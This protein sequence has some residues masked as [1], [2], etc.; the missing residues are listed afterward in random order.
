MKSRRISWKNSMKSHRRNF[1]CNPRFFKGIPRKISAGTH[2]EIL[3]G[4]FELIVSTK[5]RKFG[6]NV[7]MSFTRNYFSNTSI[8][9]LCRHRQFLENFTQTIHKIFPQKICQS[10]SFQ[11]SYEIKL[12]VHILL[13]DYDK[14]LTDIDNHALFCYFR[15]LCI[16]RHDMRCFG[17]PVELKFDRKIFPVNLNYT[18]KFRQLLTKKHHKS[19]PTILNWISSDSMDF[20]F[21]SKPFLEDFLISRY[22]LVCKT[23]DVR[24]KNP[25][26]IHHKQTLEIF[27]TVAEML[28]FKKVQL[29]LL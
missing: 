5:S 3:E 19:S 18:T 26:K 28:W 24:W 12:H 25:L 4:I 8:S 15:Q 17:K 23:L 13:Q 29:G 21:I 14:N 2:G 20:E 7:F 22:S 10:K 11:K 9:W 1:C 6:R 16:L 27:F